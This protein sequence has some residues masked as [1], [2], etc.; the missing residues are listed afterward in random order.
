MSET[1]YKKIKEIA[2][3]ANGNQL[4]RTDLAYELNI[5]DSIDVARLTW[6]AYHYYNKNQLIK[7]IFINNDSNSSLVDDYEL[8]HLIASG[9]NEEYFTALSTDLKI[10]EKALTVLDDML[11]TKVSDVST[12][13]MGD[14]LSVIAG[15][16]GI[17]NVKN[18][19]GQTVQLYGNLVNV[20]DEAK[21]GV[22]EVA[23]DFVDLR[24]EIL[25]VYEKYAQLLVDFYGDSIKKV[26]PSLFDFDSIDYLD[27]TKMFERIKLQYD[28]LSENCSVMMSEIGDSFANSVRI[29]SQGGKNMSRNGALALAAVEAVKHYMDASEKTVRMKSDLEAFKMN[30]KKDVVNIKSDY[31][32]LLTIYKTI[33]D[34][35]IPKANAYFRF[36][37][38]LLSK[39]FEQMVATLYSNAGV[40]ELVK[41][42]DN[43]MNEIRAISDEYNDHKNNVAYYEEHINYCYS[44]LNDKKDDYENAK[45]LRPNKPFFL[46]RWLT[47]GAAE[48]S[49]NQKIYK[50]NSL[51]GNVVKE[52]EN[53]GMD[54][55]ADVVELETHVKGRKEKEQKLMTLKAKQQEL[56]D[57]IL[58]KISVDLEMKKMLASHIEDIVRMLH[59]GKEILE[60]GIDE[61]SIRSIKIDEFRSNELP[62]ELKD[63]VSQ[64]KQMFNDAADSVKENI[65]KDYAKEYNEEESVELTDKTSAVIDE[66]M[67]LADSVM[68]LMRMRDNNQL[69]SEVYDAEL[70]KVKKEFD[71]KIKNIDS[72]SDVLGE[73]LKKINTAGDSD[74]LKKA[75]VELAKDSKVFANEDDVIKFLKGEIKITI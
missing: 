43:L 26:A 4:N 39:E 20:Y 27:T 3:A 33:N 12:S 23:H 54:V 60:S 44:L 68:S 53:A 71:N 7:S 24:V 36:S 13:Q 52:Y 45:S 34:L 56:T 21:D 9:K 11:K 1:T 17:Q 15:T 73:V 14:L 59:I 50:W 35:Y 28:Q 62:A 16:S 57:M 48:R 74:S 30:I 58:E 70:D 47:F 19:A 18:E 5:A 2:E 41:E 69:T 31:A 49:Y 6:E 46:V 42:R 67:R 64:F 75:F 8:R 65:A 29:A 51:Y 40:A 25:R 37:D 10:G 38:K 22:K 55:N 32:R 61:C 72:Q 63:A 66:S